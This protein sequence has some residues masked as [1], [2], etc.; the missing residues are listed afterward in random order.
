MG[1][2]PASGQIQPHEHIT[3]L[4]ERQKDRLI[5][6]TARI[7]LHIGKATVKQTLDALNRQRFSNINKLTA[8]IIAP[9]GIAFGIFIGQNRTLGLQTARETIFSEAISS[10]S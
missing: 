6:L 9:T 3:G 4:Q 1:E 2:M 7:G 5:G 10:I 8:T